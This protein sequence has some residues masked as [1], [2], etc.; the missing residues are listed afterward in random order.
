MNTK[1]L[2]Q[3]NIIMDIIFIGT[4]LHLSKPIILYVFMLIPTR[5]ELLIPKVKNWLNTSYINIL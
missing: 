2:L 4:Y 3:I 1:Y 5:F